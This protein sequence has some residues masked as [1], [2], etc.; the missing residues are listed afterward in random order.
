MTTLLEF[1]HA[2]TPATTLLDR[3][4]AV[5]TV[6]TPTAFID[7]QLSYGASLFHISE[8]A[9]ELTETLALLPL[10]DINTPHNKTEL[11]QKLTSL[12]DRLNTLTA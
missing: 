4:E 10:V 1:C 11:I 6:H 5:T 3:C 2:A 12:R 9:E 7:L 8:V